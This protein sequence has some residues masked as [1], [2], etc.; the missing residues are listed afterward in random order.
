MKVAGI[1]LGVFGLLMLLGAAEV[2]CTQYNLSDYHDVSKALGAVGFSLL[3]LGIGV[4]LFL[5]SRQSPASISAQS[6]RPRHRHQ[7]RTGRCSHWS[8]ERFCSYSLV[9]EVSRIA[10]SPCRQ[11]R[12]N[13]GQPDVCLARDGYVVG[14]LLAD[15]DDHVHAVRILFLRQRDGKNDPN[16]A[17]VSDWIG[18]PSLDHHQ[19]C[20]VATASTSW[21]SAGRGND[22]D[23]VGLVLAP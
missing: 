22:L 18:R 5:K 20:S 1:V 11:D 3:I 4:S 21:E 17:Y 6:Y 8:A 9:W 15:A 13:A 12:S 16:D 10:Q 23:G 2:I 14:G 19:R 7:C